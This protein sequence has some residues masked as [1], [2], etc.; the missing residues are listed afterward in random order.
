MFLVEENWSFELGIE[1]FFLLE[2]DFFIFFDLGLNYFFWLFLGGR[3]QLGCL[4]ANDGGPVS[5][6]GLLFLLLVGRFF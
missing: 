4:I 3:G 1:E 6:L 2:Y 5:G